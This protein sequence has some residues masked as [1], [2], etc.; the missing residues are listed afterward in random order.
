MHFMLKHIFPLKQFSSKLQE[1]EHENGK[2]QFFSLITDKY[3]LLLFS[4]WL[5]P[6]TTSRLKI[7][8]LDIYFMF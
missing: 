2:E 1:H 6:Q 4:V 3:E 7:M 5:K 8:C